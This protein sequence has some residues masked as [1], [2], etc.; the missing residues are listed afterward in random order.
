MH[1]TS[2][3]A[4]L[5]L[6]LITD[7]AYALPAAKVPRLFQRHGFTRRDLDVH[8]LQKELGPL[9]SDRATIYGPENEEWKENT[10]RFNTFTRPDVQVI[11]EPAEESDVSTIVSA[12]R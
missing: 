9:L 6:V 2:S 12:C 4:L 7:V 3:L 10:K 8:V 11:V 5:G 1:I